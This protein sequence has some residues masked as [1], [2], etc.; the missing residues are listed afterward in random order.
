MGERCPNCGLPKALRLEQVG[1]DTGFCWRND[2]ACEKTL[3][4]RAEVAVLRARIAKLEAAC[5][6]Q[7]AALAVARRVVNECGF[8]DHA[9][10]GLLVEFEQADAELEKVQ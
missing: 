4:W 8:A 6:A 2:T 5:A 1:E 9:F 10:G 3:R 7:A